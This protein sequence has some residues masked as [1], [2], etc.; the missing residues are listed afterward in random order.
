[1]KKRKM[2]ESKETECTEN[3]EVRFF[4]KHVRC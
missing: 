4:I 2:N 1:M 3:K